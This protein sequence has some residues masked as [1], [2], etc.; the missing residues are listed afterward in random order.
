MNIFVLDEDPR[1]ASK[2]LDDVRIPKMCV[3][4]AQMLASA[5]IRHG[6]Q[7]EDMPLTQ[8]GTPYKGGYHHHPCTVWA[9]DSRSNFI[10]LINHGI[11]ICSEYTHRFGKVHA[12]QGP[13]LHMQAMIDFIPQGR[14]TDFAQAMPDEFKH[15]NAVVAYRRYYHSK[16][17]S[18]GGVRYVRTAPPEWWLGGV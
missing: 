12:C 9:G 6:A 10:W 4:T 8:K 18:P 7:P 1:Q 3:E 2:Y 15:P 13:I 14:L 16:I 17:N 5:V 11:A